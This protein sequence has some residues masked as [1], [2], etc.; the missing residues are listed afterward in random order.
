MKEFFQAKEVRL[1]PAINNAM[2]RTL[3]GSV[4]GYRWEQSASFDIADIERYAQRAIRELAKLDA[5]GILERYDESVELI[6]SAVGVDVPHMIEKKQVLD[7]VMEEEP[8]LRKIEREPVTDE[9]R[10]LVQGL[11]RAD[12]KVYL[13][14]KRLFKQRLDASAARVSSRG[15]TRAHG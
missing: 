15:R 4:D 3:V 2:T 14:A 1:H 12:T 10:D 6:C 7:V 5:F 13:H 9:I 8:G 11:V